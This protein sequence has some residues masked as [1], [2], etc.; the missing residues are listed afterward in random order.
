M[1][2]CDSSV[3]NPGFLDQW[4]PQDLQVRMVLQDLQ[5]LRL[6]SSMSQCLGPL[7]HLVHQ[8]LTD[9]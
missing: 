4:G 6:K 1:C 8:D 2:F 3:V 5:V 7:A 9:L